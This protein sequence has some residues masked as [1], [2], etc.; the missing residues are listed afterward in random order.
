VLNTFEI[1][2]HVDLDIMSPNQ[3]LFYTTSKIFSEMEGVL[4]RFQ[5]DIVMTQGDTTT[6]F[7]A[8]L[9]AFYAGK[10]VAHV[11]AGLRTHDK[12]MPFPEEINRK[13]TSTVAHVHFAPTELAKKNLCDEG[14]DAST[15]HVTGNT[16]IDALLWVVHRIKGTPCPLPEFADLLDR[17][18]RMVLITGHRREHFGEPFRQICAAFKQLA[19]SYPHVAFFYPV[20]LNPNVQQPV[21]EVLSGLPNFIL[22]TPLDYPTFCWFMLQCHMI[23]TDSGGIQEEAPA[24]GKPVLVTRRVTERPEA[25]EAGMVR[26][27]G[28]DPDRIVHDATRLLDDAVFHQ[29]MVKGFSPYGDGKASERIVEKLAAL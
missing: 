20:H 25:V 13:I 18:P 4:D 7:A 1:E 8:A 19:E 22:T 23:I 27:V 17:F 11:E 28:D 26:L 16:V 21:S 10:M 2:P 29:S 9:S 24:L 6:T 12:W 15:I 14:Y 5:P 3:S